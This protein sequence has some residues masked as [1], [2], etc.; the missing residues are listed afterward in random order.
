MTWNVN[1]GLERKSELLQ[2]SRDAREVVLELN[3]DSNIATSKECLRTTQTCDDVVTT[4]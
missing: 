4:S 2:Q 3:Q 1:R